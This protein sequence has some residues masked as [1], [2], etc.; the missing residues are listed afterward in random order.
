MVRVGVMVGVAVSPGVKVFVGV[1]V[2]L[3]VFVAVGVSVS[4][5]VLLGVAGIQFPWAER[6]TEASCE[7]EYV[8][9]TLLFPGAIKEMVSPAAS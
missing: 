9:S 5:G 4:V 7:V 3:I 6:K 8:T 1:A 2:G